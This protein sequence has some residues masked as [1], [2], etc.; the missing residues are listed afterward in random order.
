M[1]VTTR[2]F[3]DPVVL[4]IAHHGLVAIALTTLLDVTLYFHAK[5]AL[6]AA[7]LRKDTV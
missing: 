6:H 4:V 1:T 3:H 7:A 2:G 5:L